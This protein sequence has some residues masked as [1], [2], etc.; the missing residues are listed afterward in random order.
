MGRAVAGKG[1]GS[2]FQG[3]RLSH[4][5]GRPLAYQASLAAIKD[6][7]PMEGQ[8]RVP[9]LAKAGQTDLK[10]FPHLCKEL[11]NIHWLCSSEQ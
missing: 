9:L 1:P 8:Q 3:S 2:R 7:C 6:L 10:D 11:S 5:L 4:S